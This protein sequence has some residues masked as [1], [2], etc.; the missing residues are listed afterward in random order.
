MGCAVFS[1]EYLFAIPSTET[2]C[3]LRRGRMVRHYLAVFDSEDSLREISELHFGYKQRLE[4]SEFEIRTSD[5]GSEKKNK[6]I[7]FIII[8]PLSHSPSTPSRRSQPQSNTLSVGA[9]SNIPNQSE[10]RQTAFSSTLYSVLRRSTLQWTTPR[11]PVTSSTTSL[12]AVRKE[13]SQLK[14]RGQISHT[15]Y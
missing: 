7:T 4:R 12:F 5:S 14:A 8:P 2:R 13:R 15:T 3:S 1:Q 9:A 11:S 6:P 10:Q